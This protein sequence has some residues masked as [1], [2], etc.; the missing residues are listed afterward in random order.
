MKQEN[1]PEILA[2]NF[3]KFK[4]TYKDIDSKLIPLKYGLENY[5]ET[6]SIWRDG[7]YGYF[8]ERYSNI[9]L[10]QS[11]G[12]DYL[13]KYYSSISFIHLFFEHLI[14]EILEDKSPIL[15]KLTFDK[16]SNIISFLTGDIDKTDVSKRQNIDY[17]IAL[18]RIEELLK[19]HNNLPEK[20]Q[21]NTKY[22]FLG[23]HIETLKHLAF[24]RN[25][26]IH[27]GNNILNKYAYE[28]FFVNEVLPLVREFI[29]TQSPAY[30]ERKIHCNVNVIDEIIRYKLVENYNDKKRIKELSKTLRRINHFKELGR[31]SYTNPVYM[32]DEKTS[33]IITKKIIDEAQLQTTFKLEI[34]KHHEIHICPCCG[35]KSLTT[36]DYWTVLVNNK[37]IVETAECIVCSY[38]INVNIGEPKEFGIMDSE[39]FVCVD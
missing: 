10:S 38:K 22:H 31:A 27:S 5:F 2:N 15:S 34:L 18:N 36:F 26:I 21:I 11:M 23:N 13:L 6:Y 33:D 32:G 4:D 12:Y 39:L 19:N 9:E 28:F 37:T 25:D 20:F 1:L 8:I 14:I 35:L 30:I 24:L 16:H 7:F 17:S 3:I 29:N